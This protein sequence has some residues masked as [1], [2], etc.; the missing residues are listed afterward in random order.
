EGA[1]ELRAG[2]AALFGGGDEERPDDGCRAVDGHRGGYF[3]EGQVAQ[4]DVHIAERIDGDATAAELAFGPGF[5]VVVAHEC[6]H[7]EGDGE[8]VVAGGEEILV[9]L[10]GLFD[11]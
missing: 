5:V 4:E 3:V 2:D 1:C 11:R 7:I 6:G 10:V 9:T 8:A